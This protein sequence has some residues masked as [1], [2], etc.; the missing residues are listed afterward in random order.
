MYAEI[1]YEQYRGEGVDILQ[2]QE[3]SLATE[4]K[5]WVGPHDGHRMHLDENTAR[6]LRDALTEFLEDGEDRDG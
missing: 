4:R 3:S 2:V 1:P 6:A 5:V